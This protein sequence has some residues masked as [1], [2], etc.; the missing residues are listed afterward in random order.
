[1]PFNPF[2]ALT[3]KIFG[4]LSLVLLAAC[5]GLWLRGNHYEHKYEQA[6]QTVAE[7][8]AASKLAEAAQ[9][10]TNRTW[11][12]E[13]ASLT[14]RTEHAEQALDEMRDAAARYKRLASVRNLRDR[15]CGAAPATPDSSTPFGDGLPDDAVYVTNED[16]DLFVRIAQ[17][18]WDTYEWS[19]R[20]RAAGKMITEVEYANLP[21][22]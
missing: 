17:E 15:T 7:L 14:K 2:S 16:Y 11:Q 10:R 20:A 1:M 6:H 19:Q 22:Q 13:T 4:G 9:A 8:K 21:A 18:R 3:S 12:V 5:L